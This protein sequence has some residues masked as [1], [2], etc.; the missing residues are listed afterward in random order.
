MPFAKRYMAALILASLC[1]AILSVASLLVQVWSSVSRNIL[2]SDMLLIPIL[3]LAAAIA[4]VPITL[5]IVALSESISDRFA[6]S[7]WSYWTTLGAVGGLLTATIVTFPIY[8]FDPVSMDDGTEIPF[9]VMWLKIAPLG[10]PS[11]GLGG[12]IFWRHRRMRG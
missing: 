7:H 11:G 10:F 4:A 1:Y 5:P 6:L 3:W 8:V 9:W 2:L 12:L